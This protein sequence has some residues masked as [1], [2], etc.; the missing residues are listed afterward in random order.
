MK[1]SNSSLVP[2][3]LIMASSLSHIQIANSLFISV[4]VYNHPRPRCDLGKDSKKYKI[5]DDSCLNLEPEDIATGISSIDTHDNWSCS[6]LLQTAPEFQVV[7][8]NTHLHDDLRM[9]KPTMLEE[10]SPW[11][12]TVT[13]ISGCRYRNYTSEP[14]CNYERRKTRETRIKFQTLSFVEI[15][16]T[17]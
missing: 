3:L 6:G 10:S 9:L 11:N 13:S 16:G 14:Y 7:A 4:T 1:G 8:T 5:E 12:M 15:F 17:T 2:L